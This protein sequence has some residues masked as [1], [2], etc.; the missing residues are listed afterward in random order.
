VSA[1]DSEAGFGVWFADSCGRTPV[2]RCGVRAL[3]R[4]RK[5]PG[6]AYPPHAADPVLEWSVPDQAV[7]TLS[8]EDVR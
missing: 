2:G 7:E 4:A 6:A 8:S 3:L 1:G 5:G